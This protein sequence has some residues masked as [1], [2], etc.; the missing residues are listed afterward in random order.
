MRKNSIKT[1]V[2]IGSLSAIMLFN[3]SG[4]SKGNNPTS[5]K[6]NS[7]TETPEDA[8]PTIT[9]LSV[10][11]GTYNTSVIIYGTNFSTTL[12]DNKVYFNGKAAPVTAATST[13]LTVTVPQDAGTGAVT[14]SVKGGTTVTGP[15]FTYSQPVQVATITSID[16]NSGG[17]GTIVKITGTG[18]S[19]TITDNKVFFNSKAAT[20]TAATATLLTITVPEGASTGV[21]TLSVSGG[22][23]ITGPT[24]TYIAVIPLSITSIDIGIGIANAPVNITGTGFSTTLSANKVFFNGKA[25]AITSATATELAVKV[26]QG[27]GCGK[28]T[29]TV[30]GITATGPDFD[31]YLSTTIT[32]LAGSTYGKTDGPTSSALFGD[33][34]ALMTDNSGNIYASD[35][36]SGSVRKITPSGSVSTFIGTNSGY[37]TMD[38]LGNIYYT[39]VNTINKMTPDG[40]ISLFSV[41][42]I[43][44]L[45]C[46]ANNNI[47]VSD[48]D[49]SLIYHITPDGSPT[50]NIP[51]PSP[52][53]LVMSL[54]G[55]MYVSTPGSLIYKINTSN[56][57]TIY[58]NENARGIAVDAN[59]NLYITSVNNDVIK[60]IDHE[61]GA[62]S[63]IAR[64]AIGKTHEDGNQFTAGFTT[65]GAITLDKAGNIYVA[66]Q[67]RIRKITIN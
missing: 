33:I 17:A 4:C 3:I 36:A 44:G 9:S 40:T 12:S 5:D 29:V 7:G 27:A 42:N 48:R 20:V 63:I 38:H 30:N 41:G 67:Y 15:T 24:F 50:G 14:L 35:N 49:R 53:G 39:T 18:F 31:Y 23:V 21:I 54:S 56:G 62:I 8:T 65:S 28:V 43:S 47:Y 22:A 6:S 64:K 66:D 16:V 45:T 55:N 26:P 37:L 2:L 61:T 34:V 10:T 58:S 11:S 19:T 60:F 1:S 59:E 57:S 51:F 32:T 52:Y 25:A 46:D 13:K